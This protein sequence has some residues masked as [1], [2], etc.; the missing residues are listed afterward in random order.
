[1]RAVLHFAALAAVAMTLGACRDEVP[2]AGLV[3]PPDYSPNYTRVSVVT[4]DGREK[5]ILVPEACLT[6]DEQSPADSGPARVPPGCANNYN[7]QRMAERK[8]DL[9]RGRTLGPA[10]AAPA[11]RAAQRYIDGRDKPVLGG[12]VREDDKEGGDLGSAPASASPR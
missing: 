6:P 3:P 11:A 9:T 4:E 2:E 12:G 10:P 8:R 1:M 7:L 5:R